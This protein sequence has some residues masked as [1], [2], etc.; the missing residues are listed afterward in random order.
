[1]SLSGKIVCRSCGG[2]Y[3]LFKTRCPHCGE[4]QVRLS[5]RTPRPT[6]AA[7]KG[8]RESAKAE[9]NASWQL[10]F[11]LCLIAAV[12]IAVIVLITTTLNGEYT[13]DEKPASAPPSAA[14]DSSTPP[15][16]TPPPSTPPPTPTVESLTITFL[17]KALTN[18]EFTA[19]VGS[20]TQLGATSLPL[21]VEGEVEWSSSN[22]DILTV[23]E[24]GLVT[25]VSKGDAKVIAR[26]YGKATEC[27]V[28]VA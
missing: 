8:T 6:D 25:A 9:Q 20:T 27:R 23:D 28:L 16:S 21:D 5:A 19:R 1:M 7:R 3:S 26:L 15:P 22:E 14:V 24:K 17:G 11:G 12:V 13:V 10:I 2:E 18:N 4:R